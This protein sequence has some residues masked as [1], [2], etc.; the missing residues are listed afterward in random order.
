MQVILLV[1]WFYDCTGTFHS[2]EEFKIHVE[3]AHR[4]SVKDYEW[5]FD[6]LETK[7]EWIKCRE[8]GKVVKRNQSAVRAHVKHHKLT[9]AKYAE[10]HGIVTSRDADRDSVQSK[11][12][13]FGG[14]F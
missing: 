4:L 5:A 14:E 8:C 1:Q 7:T 13:S 10:K 11:A 12:T 3:V 2:E 9:V 6:S